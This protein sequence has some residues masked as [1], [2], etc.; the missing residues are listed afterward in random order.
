MRFGR[1]YSLIKQPNALNTRSNEFADDVYSYRHRQKNLIHIHMRRPYVNQINLKM[2]AE[3]RKI[4][5]KPSFLI[6]LL[7]DCMR[8]FDYLSTLYREY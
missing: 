7:G 4:S 6:Y 3:L 1:F 5:V 2:P 8:D